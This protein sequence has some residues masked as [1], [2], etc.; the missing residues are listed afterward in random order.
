MDDTKGNFM[1]VFLNSEKNMKNV[2]L[3]IVFSRN[4]RLISQCFLHSSF[5]VNNSYN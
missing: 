1:Y 4:I 3:D 5:N 2:K